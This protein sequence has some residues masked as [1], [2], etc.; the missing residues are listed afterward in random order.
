MK[1]LYNHLLNE[2]IL[3]SQ[4]KNTIRNDV[5]V[6]PIIDSFYRYGNPIPD[7]KY[8]RRSRKLIIR[9]PKCDEMEWRVDTRELDPSILFNEIEIIGT[10]ELYIIPTQKSDLMY[11]EFQNSLQLVM[12]YKNGNGDTRIYIGNVMSP[13]SRKLLVRNFQP[14]CQGLIIFSALH[15]QARLKYSGYILRVCGSAAIENALFNKASWQDV[16]VN[17]LDID[18]PTYEGHSIN[19]WFTFQESG[20]GQDLG[21]R[22]AYEHKFNINRDAFKRSLT[23]AFTKS[24]FNPKTNSI[25]RKIRLFLGCSPHAVVDIDLG[26]KTASFSCFCGYERDLAVTIGRNLF[27]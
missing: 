3:G 26:T 9:V 21:I 20:T 19:N 10:P 11:L 14:V 22:T 4:D 8:T 13:N 1:N 18:D 7:I 15:T 24:A 27:K 17:I 2:S 16:D 5:E 12:N 6:Q 25:L 23:T